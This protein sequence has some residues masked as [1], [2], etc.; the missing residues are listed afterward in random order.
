MLT[1]LLRLALLFALI[2]GCLTAALVLYGRWLSS[3]QGGVTIEGSRSDLGIPHQL[4]L[5]VY[6]SARAQ[7]LR[8]PAGSGSTPVHFTIEPGETANAVAANLAAAGLL[9]D[10]ELFLNYARFY[11][12]DSR[13]EAGEFTLSPQMTIPEL[14]TAL[15]RG[16]ARDVELRFIEGW[17][18]EEMA[19]YLEE[20]EPALVVSADFLAIAR[21]QS[22][23]DTG[24]YP[25]LASLPAGV[26][27]E[28]F[29]FPDTYRVPRDAGAAYLVD[30]MLQNFGR[31]VTPAMRQAY[32]A[33]GLSLREA[34]TL[35]S[36]VEREAAVPDERPIIASVF[37]NRLAQG[38]K[39][40]ADPTVQYPLGYQANLDTWWK[41][42]LSLADLELPS[43][44][45]TYVYAGLPPG[46][47]ANPGL[48]SLQAVAEPAE[49]DYLFFVVDCTASV[50]GSHVFSTT[51]EEHLANVERCR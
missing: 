38:M 22:D 42:P 34:V 24:R 26:T 45:N 43:P 49:T 5:Q 35:A 6:L 14:A 23:F 51:Y 27:L 46:P 28:G 8:E 37:Y 21:R 3:G 25:F 12:L 18:F 48:A 33:R 7:D 40:E 36:I 32:G 15:T 16:Q 44:Y 39:L 19:N 9:A 47:I 4:Y 50:P 10:P 41:S 29:L 20:M 17:R 1:W 13:F 30:L 11:G 31:R 2:T